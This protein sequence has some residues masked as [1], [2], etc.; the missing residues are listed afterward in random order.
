MALSPGIESIE[1]DITVRI[2]TVTSSVGAIV[3]AAEKGAINKPLLINDDK[4]YRETFGEPDDV[5]YRH[6]FTGAAFLKSSDQLWVVRTEDKTK[7]VAGLTIGTSGGLTSCGT[8]L[9]SSYPTPKASEYF[10]L[11]YD[12]VSDTEAKVGSVPVFN[13]GNGKEI[14]HIYA[15][16]AGPYYEGVEV[17]TINSLDY[18]TLL[19]LKEEYVQATTSQQKQAVAK[20]YYTGTPATS[21]D[22]IW[23]GS[24]APASGDAYYVDSGNYLKCSLIKDDVISSEV[25]D[26]Q[27]VWSVDTGLLNTYT[28]FSFGP[29]ANY[30]SNTRVYSNSDE[31]AVMVFDPNGNLAEQYVVSNELDKL[32]DAGQKMFAPDV[33]NES[34][35]FIYFFIGG[36]PSEAGGIEP[37]TTGK[38]NLAGADALTTDLS[39]LSGEIEEQWREWFAN[40]ETYQIDLTFDPDYPTVLKQA[41]DDISKNIRK[42]CFTLLNV[43]ESVMVNTSTHRPIAQYI[44]S[45]KNYVANTLNIDSSYSA[46]YGQYFKIYDRF[47]EKNRWVPVTGYVAA[48]IATSDFSTAQWNAPA[49]FARGVIDGIV[50]VAITPSQAQRDVMYSNKINAIVNFNGQ[51]IVIWGQKTMQGRPS[52]FDRINVRRL[53]LHLERSI[54][55]LARYFIFEINDE[56]TRSRFRGI[57]NGFLAEIKSRRGVTDFLVVCDSTN[58]G[59][60]VIDRNE[61]VAEIL[62]KP[63]RAIEFVRLVFT[64]VSTGVS[65]SEVVGR[66]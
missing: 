51:G 12:N 6:W 56:T 3:I 54:E 59:P 46:I 60:D 41:L 13:T 48:N 45:M 2:P 20:K 14:F 17:V 50:D 28:S 44:T 4:Q 22:A 11:S 34:S 37:V 32:N 39:L 57:V 5:N 38:V 1:R 49:G 36:D 35:S 47:N 61:F 24:T 62:V 29:Q 53:F 31:F 9:I 7:M 66:G 21:A 26:N 30:D 63:S 19:E 15:V 8:P 25:I 42:D 64:A 33:I 52:A 16:G 40:K 18:K 43:P 55:K 10:P 65:F 23:A 27:E 58:N